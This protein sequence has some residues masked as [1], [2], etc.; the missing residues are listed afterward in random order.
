MLL[1]FRDTTDCFGIRYYAAQGGADVEA[2]QNTSSIPTIEAMLAAIPEEGITFAS[3]SR[4]FN[5]HGHE[6]DTLVGVQLELQKYTRCEGSRLYPKSSEES[7]RVVSDDDVR[8]TVATYGNK[9]V[10][11]LD[12]VKVLKVRDRGVDVAIKFREDIFSRK[13]VKL[14]EYGKLVLGDHPQASLEGGEGESRPAAD[15]EQ[16]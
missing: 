13:L 11:F 12:L 6:Y 4:R 9:G 7:N 14:N 2:A 16:M 3:L 15:S 10:D 1:R 5:I 8:Y